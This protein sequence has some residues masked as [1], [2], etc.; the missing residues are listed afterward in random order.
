MN[1][2]ENLSNYKEVQDNKWNILSKPEPEPKSENADSG[3]VSNPEKAS[4]SV[5]AE[6]KESDSGFKKSTEKSADKSQNENSFV[7]PLSG[8][9]A[10]EKI[11]EWKKESFESALFFAKDAGDTEKSFQRSLEKHENSM[12]KNEFEFWERDYSRTLNRARDNMNEAGVYRFTK[13]STPV[14][15]EFSEKVPPSKTIE[16]YAGK[17]FNERFSNL[18]NAIRKANNPEAQEEIAL[19]N[20]FEDKVF[21]H[22]DT[23]F[24]PGNSAEYLSDRMSKHNEVIKTLNDMNVLARKYGTTTFTARDFFPCS[25]ESQDGLTQAQVHIASYDRDVVESYYKNAFS[26]DIEKIS[27]DQAYYGN[28]WA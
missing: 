22:V 5:D 11:E 24:V 23:K 17:F 18:Y 21:A 19:L 20:S 27:Q 26:K 15:S 7:Q 28:A 9:D 2:S 14:E 6:I 12:S 13:E 4:P 10:K 8:E 16:A 25:Y 3:F 1:A